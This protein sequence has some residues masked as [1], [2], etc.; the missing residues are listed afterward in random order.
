M[1]SMNDMVAVDG[2]KV[3]GPIAG[4]IDFSIIRIMRTY[5][6]PVMYRHGLKYVQDGDVQIS[7]SW[8]IHR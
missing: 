5:N 3:Q 2:S 8:D 4:P 1:Y 6:V 7:I